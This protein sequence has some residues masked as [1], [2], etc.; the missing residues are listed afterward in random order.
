M[1]DFSHLSKTG[2]AA[3]VDISAKAATQRAALVSGEVRVSAACATR[4]TPE[5]VQEIGRT[6]RIAG[7][8]AAKQTHLLIP[9]CH[10]IP[11][12]AIDVAVAFE[13]A[14]QLFKINVRT[15]T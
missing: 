7:I 9:L 8:Q 6:A 10:P 14:E 12:T 11:L 1:G 3:L 13:A 5:A 4:L 2:E 15:A